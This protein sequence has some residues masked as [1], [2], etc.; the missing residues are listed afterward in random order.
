[1]A[2]SPRIESGAENIATVLQANNIRHFNGCPALGEVAQD[3][4]NLHQAATILKG[5][6]QEFFPS[7]LTKIA[8]I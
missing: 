2:R 4:R 7:R 1:M 8:T 3:G 5:I 6:A